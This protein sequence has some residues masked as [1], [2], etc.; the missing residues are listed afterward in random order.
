MNCTLDSLNPNCEKIDPNALISFMNI[1][2]ELLIS[3]KCF[4][5]INAPMNFFLWVKI[6]S[7]F[8]PLHIYTIKENSSPMGYFLSVITEPIICTL[9]THRSL[10][11]M[12]RS[13]FKTWSTFFPIFR[14]KPFLKMIFATINVKTLFRL[15]DKHWSPTVRL[16]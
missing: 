9:L 14:K 16:L 12:W 15:D 3:P 6:N 7:C 5:K 8:T 11:N 2:I 13:T 1:Q 4:H 10:S